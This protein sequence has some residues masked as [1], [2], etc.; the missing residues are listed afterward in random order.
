MAQKTRIGLG[1]AALG[2]PDYINIRS[3]DVDKSIEAFKSNTLKVLDDAYKLG[4]KDFDVAPSY[5][6][7]E[8][9]LLGWINSRN[10]KDI[11][12]STKFGYTYVAN[13]EIGFSGKHEIKEHSL[14]KLNEQW[15]VSKAFL[16]H[17]NI[18]QIHSATLESGVL[19]NEDVLTRL[20]ELKQ[21]YHLKI[22]ISS[23]G[24]EQTKIIHEARNLEINGQNLFDSYQ[25][26]FNIFE[27]SSYSVLNELIKEGKTIIIKE[28]LANGRIFRNNRFEKYNPVYEYLET[29]SNKYQVNS[30][31]IALRFIIDYLEP[32]LVLSGASNSVH[33]KQNLRAL[34]IRLT[35]SEISKLKSFCVSSDYYW[36][37]RSNLEWN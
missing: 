15:E 19:T 22:G 35:E 4:V 7:G 37:E 25:V 2:R 29:L 17:L 24:A 32:P 1:L 30:D 23:S 9:F 11:R 27:Q 21:K 16:P 5:G 34:D 10:Y 33:L 26:T 3:I 6:F 12:L 8:Q 20:D 13:W 18:Y 28:A 31:A 36:Q 14:E